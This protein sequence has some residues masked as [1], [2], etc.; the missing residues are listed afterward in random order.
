M[1][2]LEVLV[3]QFSGLQSQ[4]IERW[5]NN[6]WVRPDGPPGH[7]RFG[8]IDAARVGLILELRDAMA[9][10]EDA[11][12]VILSLLDQVYDLRRDLR[13]MKAALGSFAPDIDRSNLGDD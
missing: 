11:L 3:T 1:I 10:N 2:T 8:E 6:Q 9:I 7:Y 4:D 5:I 12:P 13:A